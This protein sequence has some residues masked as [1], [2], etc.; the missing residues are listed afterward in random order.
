VSAS[1]EVKAAVERFLAAAGRQ[2]LDSLPAMFAPGASIASASLRQGKWVTASQSFEAWLARLRAAPRGEPYEEPV[3]EFTVH[4]DDDQLAFV[5]ADAK[6]IR[7]G[8]VRSHNIDYFTLIRDSAG[9]WK[10]VNGSYTAKP[11]QE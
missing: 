11:A 9:D 4:I 5:R 2:D 8:K 3:T 7:N 10:F 6:L 1:A